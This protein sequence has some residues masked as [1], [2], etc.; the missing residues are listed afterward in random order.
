MQQQEGPLARMAHLREL[1]SQGNRHDPRKRPSVRGRLQPGQR[2]Q[3]RPTPGKGAL[4]LRLDRLQGSQRSL[5]LGTTAAVVAR[6]VHHR[7]I[8]IAGHAQGQVMSPTMCQECTHCELVRV[9]GRRGE[10]GQQIPVKL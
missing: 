1:P 6:E 10:P 3:D 8:H 5:Q 7:C 9:N 4:Q 2:L